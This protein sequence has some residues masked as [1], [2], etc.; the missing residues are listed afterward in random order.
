MHSSSSAEAEHCVLQTMKA[1]LSVHC[2]HCLFSSRRFNL[3]ELDFV[4]QLWSIQV[5]GKSLE[6][7][8][9]IV[10]LPGIIDIQCIGQG[11][12]N[13]ASPGNTFKSCDEFH[14]PNNNSNVLW[15]VNCRSPGVCDHRSPGVCDHRSPG[16]CDH[17]NCDYELFMFLQVPKLLVH[18][19]YATWNCNQWH[20]IQLKVASLCIA[21]AWCFSGKYFK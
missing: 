6:Y 16:V 11:K 18:V 13:R 7:R 8:K 2:N 12:E 10:Q 4:W 20:S 1:H 15:A 17:S 9:G 5:L 19:C 3:E 21:Q 14:T